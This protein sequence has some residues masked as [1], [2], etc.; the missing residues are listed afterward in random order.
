MWSSGLGLVLDTIRKPPPLLLDEDLTE[1]QLPMMRLLK[2][3]RHADE[4]TRLMEESLRKHSLEET[5][6]SCL[7]AHGPSQRKKPLGRACL[8]ARIMKSPIK[9]IIH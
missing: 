5:E 2:P 7:E 1:A 8:M 4:Q 3:F 6:S 9:D